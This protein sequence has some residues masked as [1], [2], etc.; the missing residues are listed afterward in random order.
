MDS[1]PLAKHFEQC[2]QDIKTHGKNLSNDDLQTLYGL[3]KQAS[4]GDNKK[5]APSFYQLTE[6]AKWN[7]WTSQ[8]GKPQEQ[9]KHEYVQFCMKFLPD[10]VKNAYQ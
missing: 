9:A 10:N 6:K 4:E 7:A 8:K 1:F 5:D 3:F 2:A